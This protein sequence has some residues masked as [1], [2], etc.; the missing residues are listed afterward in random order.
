MQAPSE[1]TK[2]HGTPWSSLDLTNQ[3]SQSHI[4]E[5]GGGTQDFCV[6]YQWKQDRQEEVRHFGFESTSFDA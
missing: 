5:Y 2:S 6:T 3:E 1:M 4:H